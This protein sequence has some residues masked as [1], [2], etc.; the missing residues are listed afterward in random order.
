MR[1]G[2]GRVPKQQELQ[3]NQHRPNMQD[4]SCIVC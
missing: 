1:S 3:L 4:P 2:E